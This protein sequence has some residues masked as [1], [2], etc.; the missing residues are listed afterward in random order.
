MTN[1]DS[2]KEALPY[3][4]HSVPKLFHR[5]TKSSGCLC[6]V[7][8]FFDGLLVITG[9]YSWVKSASF[10]CKEKSLPRHTRTSIEMAVFSIVFPTKDPT[11]AK[12]TCSMRHAN[13]HI[14]ACC[15]T[16]R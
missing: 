12:E 8:L 6:F 13:A 16:I 3:G 1:D 11:N 14:H 7:R 9:E 10:I 5:N 15:R 4:N 2:I